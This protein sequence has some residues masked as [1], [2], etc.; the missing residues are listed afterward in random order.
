MSKE[1]L[2]LLSVKVRLFA[3][4]KEIVG[5]NEII[6][7]LARETTVGDLKKKILEMHPALRKITFFVAVNHK[8]ADDSTVISHLDE[9]AVLPPVSGG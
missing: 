5:K 4:S 9:L 6:M 8:V 1:E 2:D 3:Y 7:S